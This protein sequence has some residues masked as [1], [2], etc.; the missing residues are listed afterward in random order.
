MRRTSALVNS[1]R[2]N[3]VLARA[4]DGTKTL[5]PGVYCGGLEI[6]S[7]AIVTMN[8]GLYFIKG[9]TFKIDSEAKVTGTG[10]SFYITGSGGWPYDVPIDWSSSD[11]S[12]SAPTAG[13]LK[14]LV[15]FQDPA[16]LNAKEAVIDSSATVAIDGIMYFPRAKLKIGSSSSFVM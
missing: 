14:G 16:A 9:K 1:P 13:P 12:L 6:K 10:V 11:I 8:P 7:T 15:I 2:G 3:R 5:D 4:V